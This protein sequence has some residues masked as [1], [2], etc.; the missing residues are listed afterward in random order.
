MTATFVSASVLGVWSE[1]GRLLSGK[2]GPSHRVLSLQQ[3][4]LFGGKLQNASLEVSM[5]DAA[6][7]RVTLPHCVTNLSW[8]NWDPAAWEDVWVY[9]RHFI[10]PQEFNGL[11]LFLEFDRVMTCATPALN[12]H[13]L[14]EHQGGFLPFEYEITGLVENENVLTVA[15]DAR[16]KNVPPEGN[17]RGPAS[18]DYLMPGGI[19]GSA[20]LRA[21][22]GVF[23][24][25]VFAK[26][27]NVLGPDRALEL[28][29]RIDAGK[30]FPAAARLV[31]TLSGNGQTI[32][33][34]AKDIVLE[35]TDQEISLT[36]SELDAVNLWDL[37][38]PNL[39]D[40]EVTLLLDQRP[41]HSHRTRVGFREAKFTTD[42]FFL[43]G[44]RVQLFGLDRHELYPYLG[45]AA[46]DRLLRRDAEILRRQFNCNIVRC[47][48]YPQSEAFL[49]ACDELGLMVWEETPGW[50]YLGDDSWQ[51]LVVQNVGDMVRRDRNHAS[52]V[53]WGVRV[54]ESR[55]DPAL[56]ARTRALAYS[57]DGSRPT[58]GS[59]TPDSA[60]DFA[61]WH[62]DV[63][64]FDDYHGPGGGVVSIREPL[65]GVPYMLTETVGQFNYNS[66]KGFTN[67][68]RRAGDPD[69]Q[70][71][72]ALFHAQAHSKAAAYPRCAGAIAWCAI[73]YASLINAYHA[74]KYPGVADV[75][76]IPKLGATFY[77]AQ[78]DPR[79]R[80]VIEPDFYWDFGPHTPSGPG[81]HA[82]IFSNCDQLKVL[83]D[84]KTHAALQPDRENFP[85]IPY[86]PFFVDLDID[87]T[88]L[89]ELR[90]QGYVADKLVLSRSFSSNR[91]AD[92]L[93][94]HADDTDLIADG[95][96]ATRLAFAAVDKFG[97]LRP[98]V[99]GDV[100]LQLSGPAAIVGD[101]PF[102]LA[103]NGGAGAV[104]IRTL[105]A[106][107]GLVRVEAHHAS[108][109]SGQ[110][111]LHIR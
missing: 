110:V 86:P 71:Q 65:P 43:N 77:L 52:I 100:E 48:H 12:G 19:T 85:H 90:I 81:K 3:D 96:D 51:E 14:A 39:Y 32:A 59:M 40:V 34:T 95:S 89:P 99:D 83:V 24:R 104:W 106:R 33:S 108:L 109:G 29:C 68:Y 91:S 111:E 41:I 88:K 18:V 72:Q 50:G 7:P 56:Y 15:V 61:N 60:K 37:K 63:F 16:W 13:T 58:S 94:L 6:F 80:A 57:L 4:W 1:E 69:L 92:K 105:A 64:A 82:A 67:I 66:G 25:D 36:L 54:N 76:R 2:N 87:G 93:W 62:Q 75:F 55:N 74:I 35:K 17:P 49:D 78:V 22:P 30:T 84:G 28:R 107:T 42:G 46:P 103:G 23:I 47:S 97:A 44:R 26:P 10:V 38:T 27:V 8:Q 20:R 5:D 102:S 98:Y 9:R 79:I 31:A 70:M 101:N 11:R 21:V 45:F 73:E 53:I